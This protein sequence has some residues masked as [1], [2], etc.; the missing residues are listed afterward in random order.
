[1]R[2]GS[3]WK[4][5]STLPRNTCTKSVHFV[6]RP[7]APLTRSEGKYV[8]FTDVSQHKTYSTPHVLCF[9]FFCFLSSKFLPSLLTN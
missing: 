5:V 2:Q 4:L 3:I 7:K 6:Q 8:T 1:M 9:V